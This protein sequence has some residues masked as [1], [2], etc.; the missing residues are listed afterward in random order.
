MP[1]HVS[2]RLTTSFETAHPWECNKISKVLIFSIRSSK[3]A[4]HTPLTKLVTTTVTVSVPHC[5]LPCHALASEPCLFIS[6]RHVP[7]QCLSVQSFHQR[8]TGL[9]TLL[10]DNFLPITDCGKPI[11]L[12]AQSIH[13]SIHEYD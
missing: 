12:R 10:T 2:S 3:N 4:L 8:F 5:C 13:A 7:D 1:Q 9:A 11:N 6:W